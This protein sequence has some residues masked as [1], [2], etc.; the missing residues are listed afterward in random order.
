MEAVTF[1]G[2]LLFFV[3]VQFV[4]T[5]VILWYL[6]NEKRAEKIIRE[7]IKQIVEEDFIRKNKDDQDKNAGTTES[8]NKQPDKERKEDK[9]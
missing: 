2:G 5:C 1:L 6:F 7:T 4:G 3:F 8:S 9:A